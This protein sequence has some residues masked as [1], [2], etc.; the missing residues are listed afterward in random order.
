VKFVNETSEAHLVM[1]NDGSLSTA[2]IAPGAT[3]NVLTMP[4]AGTNYHCTLHSNMG[5]AIS[6][7]N[8]TPPPPC[9]GAYCY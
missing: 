5:G 4:S 9:E 2:T 1:L 6:G 7:A 3:S 8:N